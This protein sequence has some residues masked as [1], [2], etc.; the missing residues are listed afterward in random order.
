MGSAQE[1]RGDPAAKVNFPL[2]AVEMLTDRHF[3]VAGGGGA[4]KTGVSNGF[5]TYQLTFNGEQCV[6]TQVGKHDTGS[7][8]VM[9]CATYED[10]KSKSKK[11]YFVAGLDDHS[12]LYYINKKFEIARSYSYSDQN[13]NEKSPDNSVR[14]RKPSEN[15]E[16]DV[17]S[18][19]SPESLR[20]GLLSQR[21][22]R[23][24]AHPM[25]SVK[26]DIG[27]QEESFQKVA[28]ISS[29]GKLLA[30]GGCDG[31][32][33]L[34]QFPT[35]KPLRDIKSHEKEVDDMDFS[36]DSQKIVSVS[37]DGCAFVWNSKDGN[38]LCQLE[39]TPPD[40]AK[41]LFK[42]CRFSVG[43]GDGQRPR[44]F[45]I[46]NP[47]KSKLPS[48]LQLWDTSSFLLIKSVA[49]NSSPISALATSPCGKFVA[50]GSMF[51][52]SIDIYTAFNL[53]LVKRVENAHSN[54]IT[55]LAFVPCHTEVGQ[56]ITGL[57]E[58]AVISISVDNQIRVHR[59]PHRRNLLPLWAALLIIVIVVCLAFSV[60][61]YLGL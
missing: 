38:K 47:I 49:Y 27:P 51:G 15:K 41:Y 45:T 10:N 35:L 30:T 59:I 58:G 18:S 20:K 7:R 4:A 8:A 34:W 23:M 39:W 46:T 60:C 50:I 36:P 26:T 56:N 2:Y 11:I 52:G 9:N 28:R 3:V 61:S 37:K 48:F 6:A 29:S 44:L 13:E 22:L 32:I 33:R 24:L 5:A 31:Y 43:E 42:R 25:D 17:D 21:R 12:Q 54:F 40:N 1:L 57:S 16:N 53:Q 55:G 14:K 19:K